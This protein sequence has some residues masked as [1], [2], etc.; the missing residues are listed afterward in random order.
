MEPTKRIEGGITILS[1]ENKNPVAKF[2]NFP[3]Y[4]TE[5]HY[6]TG[7]FMRYGNTQEEDPQWSPIGP[8]IVDMEIST[9][10]HQGCAACYKS[11][12]AE[13]QNMSIDTYKKILNK[14]GNQMTQVALGIGSLWA[15]PDL[16]AILAYTR[17]RKVV[18]NIT[19]NGVYKDIKELE[20]LR[21][22]CGAVAV[23]LY[24]YDTCYNTIKVLTQDIG[25]PYVN[26]HALLSEE[27]YDKCMKVIDDSLTDPRL[28]KMGHIVMLWLK[29][30]GD[31]N[32]LHQLSVDKYERLINYAQEKGARIGFDSCSANKFEAATK[33]NGT[34]E[35]YKNY[36]EPCESALFSYYIN[37]DGIGTPCS[38]CEQNG[39]FKGIDVSNCN[40]FMKEV[41]MGEE[42]KA[43]RKN[44]L[45]HKRH[46]TAFNLEDK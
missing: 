34:Y 32:T 15:N 9:I 36:V 25:M 35:A 1:D 24:D 3:G 12:T 22:Y 7:W 38:F 44:L 11:C 2:A 21:K 13:G 26:I 18:P 30:C 8:E 16:E 31:R 23:S 6:K 37:V 45:E 42:T 5:F 43:F 14:A 27:S 40:D 39:Q 17:E 20:M 33:K 10:C 41:W 28:A 46:C 19:I 4:H 29:P